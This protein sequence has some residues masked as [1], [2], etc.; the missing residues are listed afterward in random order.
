M[1][2]R[3]ARQ[4]LGT[5]PRSSETTGKAGALFGSVWVS[6][7]KVWPTRRSR[8]ERGQCARQ[9]REKAGGYITGSCVSLTLSG[10]Q[11]SRPY[12]ET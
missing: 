6:R 4:G 5:C 2:F 3:P 9:A 12:T 7:P 1:T 8:V 10:P 11:L